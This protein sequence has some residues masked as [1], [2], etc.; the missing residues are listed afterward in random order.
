MLANASIKERNT[1]QLKNEKYC[2]TI[3]KLF[4]IKNKSSKDP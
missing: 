2:V 4:A 1:E 3:Q